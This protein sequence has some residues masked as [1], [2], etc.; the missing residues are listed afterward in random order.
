MVLTSTSSE[1]MSFCS[2]WMF[3]VCE[4]ENW[5]A[6]V[7]PIA[8]PDMGIVRSCLSKMWWRSELFENHCWKLR[9]C[10]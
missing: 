5:L 8:K 4:L 2:S 10:S 3:L 6:S 9:V 7:R 1:S